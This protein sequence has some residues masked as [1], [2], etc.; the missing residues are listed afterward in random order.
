MWCLGGLLWSSSSWSSSGSEWWRAS[1][2]KYLNVRIILASVW[3]V[4][5]GMGCVSPG[6][7]KSLFRLSKPLGVSRKLRKLRGPLLQSLNLDLHNFGLDLAMGNIYWPPGWRKFSNHCI[8]IQVALVELKRVDART[9]RYK[10]I[11]VSMEGTWATTVV[12]YSC[13]YH[14]FT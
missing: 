3:G 10:K 6:L 14:L 1:R 4:V 12:P 5:T 8:G 2:S 13:S 11:V 9:Y 7:S